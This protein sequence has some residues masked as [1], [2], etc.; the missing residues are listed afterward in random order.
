MSRSAYTEFDDCDE[1][2]NLRVGGWQANVRRAL[3]GKRGQ[4]FLWELYQALEAMPRRELITGALVNLEGSC[5]ALG[6]VAVKRGYDIPEHWR[7]VP[8]GM[9]EEC[10]FMDGLGYFFGIKDMLAQE[11]MYLNDDCGRMHFVD[12]GIRTRG[13]W[14]VNAKVRD[15]TDAERW[16]RMREW[17]VSKLKGIP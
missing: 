4:A 14:P 15:E 1:H 7:E 16:Q 17:V 6:A 3:G 10:D 9:P 5:C 11:I 12:T 2:D 8:E 13:S